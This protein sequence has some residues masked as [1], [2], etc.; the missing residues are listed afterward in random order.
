MAACKAMSAAGMQGFASLT[1]Q[2]TSMQQNLNVLEC[3][4]REVGL[5]GRTPAQQL[6]IRCNLQGAQTLRSC[7]MQGWD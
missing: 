2:W 7:P 3:S 5:K 1:P 4:S 6:Y